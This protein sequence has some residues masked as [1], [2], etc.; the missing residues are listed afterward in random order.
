MALFV[1]DIPFK[2]SATDIVQHVLNI[3]SRFR[4]NPTYSSSS[5]FY[6]RLLS[7]VR[8]VLRIRIS[9]I[10][11]PNT[12]YRF[13][14]ARRNIT[15]AIR[16]GSS[17]D[18]ITIPAGNY[19]AY[20]LRDALIAAFVAAGL[21][22]LTVSFDDVSALFTFT[23]LQAFVLDTAIELETNSTYNRP[24]DYGLGFNLGFGRGTFSSTSD[25]ANHIVR[26]TQCASLA[27]DP[28]VLLK[29]ND[30]DCVRQ[31][32]TDSD[33]SALAKINPSQ[34]T[35]D[36]L[37]AKEVTFPAPHDLA[38]FHIQLLDPYGNPIDMCSSQISFSIEVLE[39][40]KLS[41]YNTIRDAFTVGWM[42][43]PTGV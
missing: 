21:P 35:I 4:E 37:H 6:F 31:T 29:I 30:F 12:Y 28:Y 34:P 8:N 1:P 9:S 20:Q 11:M 13:S 23:G 32:I 26:S 5:D 38:R 24:F 16:H 18:V 39:V 33:L 25:G 17:T 22:W 14:A 10:E 2:L 42:V 7:P 36:D 41:L 3:D 19:T 27:G 40:R 15:I 43:G